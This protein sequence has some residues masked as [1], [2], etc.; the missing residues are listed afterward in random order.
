MASALIS[1]SK[2]IDSS[3]TGQGPSPGPGQYNIPP[4]ITVS[5]PNFVGFQSSAKRNPF[6][7]LKTTSPSPMAYLVRE[8]LLKKQPVC[9]SDFNSKTK[10][11]DDG[12]AWGP[13]RETWTE[14]PAMGKH[15]KAFPKPQTSP[16]IIE[17]PPRVPSI[18]QRHQSYG[19]EEDDKTGKLVLQKP[20]YPGYTGRKND[21]VGPMDYE[22]KHIDKIKTT[23]FGKGSNRDPYKHCK[24]DGPGPGYY[25]AAVSSFDDPASS[26]AYNEGNYVMRLN[27]VRKQQSAAFESKTVRETIPKTREVRPDPGSYTLPPAI[28]VKT[29]APEF[30]NFGSSD[31]RI[32]DPIARSLRLTIAPGSYDP[33]T[34]DFDNMYA[35]ILRQKRLTIKSQWAQ[36]ISFLGTDSRLKVFERGT[37]PELVDAAYYP[38]VN[39][40]DN[41]PRPTK[42]GPFGS[43]TERFNFPDSAYRSED[44]GTDLSDGP[45]RI[46]GSAGRSLK[47]ENPGKARIINCSLIG[48]V[49]PSSSFA[50]SKERFQ[51]QEKT[52]G[53]PPGTYNV[54]PSWRAQGVVP[55]RPDTLG[56]KQ[57]KIVHTMP[58]PG[59][60]TI[61]STLKIPRK[62]RKN[63]MVSTV[64][65]FDMPRVEEGPGPMDYDPI[66]LYGNMIRPS[67][68]VMLSST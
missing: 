54:A 65:R 15:P 29:K 11:F 51:E 17:P 38:K 61:P 14:V 7:S 66:P 64:Q 27:S 9:S 62:N 2:R 49:Q 48:G 56:S 40:A 10:R 18:P 42:N 58:G 41:L 8:N 20:S 45:V 46:G 26:S 60:Y 24:S 43:S 34:S 63:I 22:P 33:L 5:S 19:F 16:L 47:H 13:L 50:Y 35:K 37:I 55:M 59:D 44:V 53:P 4:A 28:Q 52:M 21:T 68:N 32:K 1:T 36:S 3:N 6:G 12:Q 23:N 39:I 25:N 30:Q 67:H 57:N 31:A